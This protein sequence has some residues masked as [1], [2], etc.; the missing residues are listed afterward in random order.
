MTNNLQ[1]T[2]KAC[3]PLTW[4][5]PFD[6]LPKVASSP[7]YIYLDSRPG[8]SSRLNGAAP[9]NDPNISSNGKPNIRPNEPEIGAP[10]VG[11][12]AAAAAG[13]APLPAGAGISAEDRVT[14]EPAKRAPPPVGSAAEAASASARSALTGLGAWGRPLPSS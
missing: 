14:T 5:L 11:G 12:I 6:L 8:R 1:I 4:P 7:L 3:Q 2:A 9:S 10:G 13:T